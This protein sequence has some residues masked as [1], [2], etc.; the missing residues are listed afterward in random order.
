MSGDTKTYTTD[1]WHDFYAKTL[2][3]EGFDFALNK[4][5]ERRNVPP[6][7]ILKYTNG[8]NHYASLGLTGNPNPSG[9]RGI[10]MRVSLLLRNPSSDVRMDEVD[11][12]GSL[13][14]SCNA[15]TERSMVI[16]RGA[17][18]FQVEPV[19]LTSLE[20]LDLKQARNLGRLIMFPRD[21]NMYMILGF[22]P[23]LPESQCMIMRMTAND[24]D[25]NAGK[26]A[27][28]SINPFISTVALGKR[29]AVV[30]K[31]SIHHWIS[32]K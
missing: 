7:M 12:F 32:N 21:K 25:R 10:Y 30:G 4:T 6:G 5:V 27:V 1:H 14:L 20:E 18:H 31:T 9:H 28:S 2:N 17:F 3:G 26:Q 13:T 15:D 8:S 22:A 24:A 29:I 11:A 19:E 16:I 23:E